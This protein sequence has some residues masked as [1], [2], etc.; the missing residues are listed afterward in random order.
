MGL[1]WN[2]ERP[3]PGSFLGEGGKFA[4]GKR[5]WDHG[6]VNPEGAVSCQGALLIR[7]PRKEE[8]HAL[9]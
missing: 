8:C 7:N 4:S 2:L 5:G 1:V 6:R 9:P 3:R